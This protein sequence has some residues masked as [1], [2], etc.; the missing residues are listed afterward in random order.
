M[1]NSIKKGI[2]IILSAPSGGGK[3]S[4]AKA[5]LE[6]DENLVLSISATTREKRRRDVDGVH[7][8]FKSRDEF[9][10]MINNN[11][12]FEYAEIYG[13]LYGTPKGF[14]EQQINNGKDVIFDID[15]QGAYKLMDIIKTPL[16]SIFIK[17]P[18][19]SAL[20]E[21]LLSRGQ[22]SKEEIAFRVSLAESEIEH[23]KNYD[24]T[25]INDNFALT[26]KNLQKIINDARGVKDA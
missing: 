6:N 14:V 17:P 23:A 7:Y 3:S 16:L 9:L 10:Q 25:V 18:S 11:D 8:F 15:F 26:V 20:R 5:L 19:I 13:N 12:L 24:Y 21:R 4:L 22:D 1:T 2:I